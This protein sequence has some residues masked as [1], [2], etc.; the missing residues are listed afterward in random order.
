MD[1]PQVVRNKA[2]VAGAF[3]W[4]EGL[5]TMIAELESEWSFRV[6]QPLDGATEAYVVEVELGNGEPAVLKVLVPRPSMAVAS[7]IEVLRLVAGDGCPTLYRSDP[8]RSAILMERLG[9]S[10]ESM[11][12]AVEERHRILCEAASRIW[13]RVDADFP[14]G[15]EKGEWLI[16]LVLEKWDSLGRPLP[17]RV[18]DHAISCARSRVAAHDPSRSV[19]VHGDVHQWNALAHRDGFKLI[20][21][22]GIFAE[23]EYDM[24]VIMREDPVELMTGDPYRRATRLGSMTGLDPQAIWEWGAVERVATGLVLTEI[25]L[26]PVGRQMLAAAE[27]ASGLS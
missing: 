6:T 4:A 23:P 15:A 24:G 2:E 3:D 5:P 18:V 20:D 25:D 27:Y 16:D 17:G 21:P 26:Q 10:L 9:P 19:L 12:L 1:I 22:D 11:G 14:S 13:R 8:D 7:E